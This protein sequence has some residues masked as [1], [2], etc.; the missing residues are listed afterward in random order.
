MAALSARSGMNEKPVYSASFEILIEPVTLETQIISSA[1][2]DTLSNRQDIVG[3]VVDDVQ[4][5]ILKSPEVIEPI[6][7]QLK[8]KYPKI[9]Y[10]KI[11]GKLDIKVDVATNILEVGYKS[12]D[13]ELVQSVLDALAEAYLNYSLE[14]R[15]TDIR[16]G[17][18]FVEEQLPQLRARVD[19]LQSQL[20][21]L[22]QR[23]NLVDPTTTGQ[24]LSAQIATFE[25]QRLDTQFEL[26][27]AEALYADLQRELTEKPA[28]IATTSLLR[29]NSRYQELL[30][31][32]LVLDTQLAQESALFLEES[33]EIEILQEKRARLIPLLEAE[34]ER[35]QRDVVSDIRELRTRDRILT[36]GVN[37]LNN[38]VKQ[39]SVIDRDYTNIQRELEIAAANLNQFLEKREAFRIDAAQREIP[40][41]LLTPPGNPNKS[42]AADIKK[43]LV[44][45]GILG[46]LLGLGAALAI[47]RFRNVIYV[48]KDVKSFAKTPLLGNIPY[49]KGLGDLPAADSYLNLPKPMVP[50]LG[51]NNGHRPPQM[52]RSFFFLESFRS[53]YTNLRPLIADS[54]SFSVVVSSSVSEEGKST[55]AV[56]LAQAAAAM[57]CRVLLVDADL[58]NPTIHRHIGVSNDC[59]LSEAIARDLDMNEAIQRSPLE[60]NLF[61]LTAGTVS[62][63]PIRLLASQRMHRLREK[64]AT[65]FDLVIYDAPPLL[66]FA[67]TYLLA[68]EANGMILV[69]GLGK[70]RRPL[71]SQALEALRISGARLLGAVANGSR[72]GAPSVPNYYQSNQVNQANQTNHNQQIPLQELEEVSER[73]EYIKH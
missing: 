46:T 53:L 65:N 48:A 62:S 59:G 58:R 34:G 45:G 16:R 10:E 44:L 13:A 23:Y 35:V 51:W 28:E 6:V 7:A 27:E 42:A 55:V 54:P 31:Q 20:Q 38:Q 56:N 24:Q 64:L 14:V 4:I 66:G 18:E 12:S 49:E 17:I 9:D 11:A 41:Q 72:E 40:W 21:E 50:F 63:D 30:S 5:R 61:V 3:V 73:E 22:R 39:L 60:D 69:A 70:I 36:Q 68:T 1:N 2:P 32:L 26:D 43:N 19:A 71:L 29:Q 15:Q 25:Q 37:R 8:S 57:D 47:D 67:D 33:P 52:N